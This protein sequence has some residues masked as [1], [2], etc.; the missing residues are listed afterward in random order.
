[1]LLLVAEALG[2][3]ERF[4]DSEQFERFLRQNE[5]VFVKYY[6]EQCGHCR[7]L[8]PRYVDL[9]EL[10]PRVRLAEFNCGENGA[11]CS[12]RGISGVPAL[13]LYR[14]GDEAAEFTS[15]YRE[16][17]KLKRWLDEQVAAGHGE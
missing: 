5:Y 11:E 1:M 10:V 4:N 3:V 2:R 8:K 9:E 6:T 16:P 7:R 17:R 15:Q 12:R 13:K 14:H